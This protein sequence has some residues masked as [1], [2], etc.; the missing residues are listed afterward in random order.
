[1][2]I[3]SSLCALSAAALLAVGCGGDSTAPDLSHV[4][5]YTMTSIDGQPLPLN[6][7][8][9]PTLI[10]TVQEGTL[11]L[12][13][14]NTFTQ[15]T[16]VDVVFN[17]A[18]QPTQ[19]FFCSGTYRRAGN[20]FTFATAASADCDAGSATGTLAG[21]TLTVNDQGTLLEYHR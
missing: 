13:R 17:G 3:R 19:T 11:T 4:G 21:T 7:S 16:T 9:D 18:I 8:D 5:A 14:N 12:S 10:V 6:I 20:N 2:R 15:G 1:M